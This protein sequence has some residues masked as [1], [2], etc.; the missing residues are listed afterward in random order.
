LRTAVGI[1]VGSATDVAN[2][3]FTNVRW[4]FG[5]T[6]AEVIRS[7]KSLLSTFATSYT[8]KP[9]SPFAVKR[10]SPRSWIERASP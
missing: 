4:P 7:E 1:V 3:V 10:Y 2:F 6:G 9:S 8:S 5:E